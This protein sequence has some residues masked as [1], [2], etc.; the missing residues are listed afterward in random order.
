MVEQIAVLLGLLEDGPKSSI[1]LRDA[2]GV[3][4]REIGRLCTRL[5]ALQQIHYVG[6][7][8]GGIGRPPAIWKLGSKG[9]RSYDVARHTV[10]GF[11]VLEKIKKIGEPV[12]VRQLAETLRA[13]PRAINQSLY[14]LEKKG[15]IRI[16]DRIPHPEVYQAK[17]LARWVAVENSSEKPTAQ[18]KPWNNQVFAKIQEIG[19]PVT[20]LEL[21]ELLG[22]TR[23]AVQDSLTRLRRKEL[24]EI[25]QWVPHPKVRGA[26]IA[27]W[28]V[29]NPDAPPVPVPVPVPEPHVVSRIH[30][31][32][33]DQAWMAHWQNYKAKRMAMLTQR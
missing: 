18:R 11:S 14:R 23:C 4:A 16:Y 2:M 7:Q 8:A 26:R 5:A 27:Q 15:L 12:H 17:S 19:D 9:S 22:S 6:K 1:A 24:I 21:V 3:T 30:I 31:T 32:P 33:E 10:S 28:Q 13:T 20:T 25:R 29:R